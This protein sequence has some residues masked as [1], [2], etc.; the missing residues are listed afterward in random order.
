M[1]DVRARF[2]CM[3]V[4]S[5]GWDDHEHL[6]FEFPPTIQLSRLVN[7]LK[8]VSISAITERVP[9]SR[10]QVLVGWAL[11]VSVVVLWAQQAAPRW[12]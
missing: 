9:F 7:S 11:L 12:A 6:L 2:G 3:L 10:Q 5:N 1:R 4:W 8:G